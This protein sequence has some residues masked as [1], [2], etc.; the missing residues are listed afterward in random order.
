MLT[1]LFEI[2]HLV[3]NKS[4]DIVTCA[5]IIRFMTFKLLL[6]THL[7]MQRFRDPRI[8]IFSGGPCPRTH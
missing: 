1:M 4:R 6:K 8:Q 5:V 2:Y 3:I 7:K